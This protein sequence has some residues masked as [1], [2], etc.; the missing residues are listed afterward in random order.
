MINSTWELKRYSKKKEIEKG[1][2]KVNYFFYNHTTRVILNHSEI[3]IKESKL[4]Q[5]GCRL[6]AIN[7]LE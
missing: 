2:I 7:E 6:V 4:D 5:Q 1:M 3:R